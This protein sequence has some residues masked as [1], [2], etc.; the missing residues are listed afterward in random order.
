MSNLDREMNEAYAGKDGSTTGDEE[1]VARSNGANSAVSISKHVS[2]ER[3]RVLGV[4]CQLVES[5][6]L[7]NA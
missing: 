1:T 3:P 6:I 4:D 2:S 5:F 7:R